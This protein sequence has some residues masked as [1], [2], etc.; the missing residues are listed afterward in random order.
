[1]SHELETTLPIDDWKNLQ[2]PRLY[3]ALML[4]GREIGDNGRLLLVD[5]AKLNEVFPTAAERCRVRCELESKV[6]TSELLDSHREYQKLVFPSIA[7]ELLDFDHQSRT[8]SDRIEMFTYPAAFAANAA[9]P[10]WRDVLFESTK[11]KLAKE[12]E[13]LERTRKS[14]LRWATLLESQNREDA[15]K[16]TR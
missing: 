12:A 9:T 16:R 5:P 8:L 7:R 11:K 6:L 10:F 15:S 13:D 1:M 14:V 3:Y 2:I 4:M